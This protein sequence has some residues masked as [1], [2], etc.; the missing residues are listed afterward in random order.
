MR[1]ILHACGTLLLALLFVVPASLT[2]HAQAGNQLRFDGIN[3]RVTM[4]AFDFANQSFTIEFWARRQGGF[5]AYQYVFSQGSSTAGE[6]AGVLFRLNN[7]LSFSFWSDDL[8]ATT[9]VTDINWHH[10][11]CTYNNTTRLQAIYIDGVLNASRTA[12][13][14]TT[15]VGTAYLGSVGGT[16]QYFVGMMD[17]FRVWNYDLGAAVI[18]QRKNC[19]LSGSEPG[20][21]RY[22]RFNQG[23]GAGVNT[24]LTTLTDASPTAAN[25]TLVNFALSG[26]SSNWLSAS[27]A[28]ISGTTAPAAPTVAA[29]GKCTGSTLASLSPAPASTTLWFASQTSTAVLPSN[30]VLSSG[31]YF[32]A[33]A[34]T[35]GCRSSRSEAA[36]TIVTV[37]APSTSAQAFCAAATVNDLV[38]DGASIKWYNTP[39]GGSALPLSTNLSTR[40]Y[41]ASQTENGCESG[42]AASSVTVKPLPAAPTPAAGS[43][44]YCQNSPT[45][46]LA[47]TGNNLLWYTQ[48]SG[49]TASATAP[50]PSSAD[51]G[52]STW[53]VSQTVAGCEGPMAPIAV[54]VKAVFPITYS[55]VPSSFCIGS[56]LPALAPSGPGPSSAPARMVTTLAGAPASGLVDAIG[57]AAR[58]NGPTAI[59]CDTAGNL[60]V[61]DSKNGRIRRLARNGVVTTLASGLSTPTG[62]AIDAGGN[63]YVAEQAAHRIRTVTPQGVVTILAGGT[64]GFSNGVGTSASFNNPTALAVDESGNVYV[65]DRNNHCIRKITPGGVVT[66]FAGARTGFPANEPSI[67]TQFTSPVAIARTPS[68]IIYVA[69]MGGSRIRKITQDSTVS[70][71]AGGSAGFSDGAAATASFFHPSGIAVDEAG[72]VYIGDRGNNRIRKISSNGVVSTIAGT[73]STPSADGA[74]LSANVQTPMGLVFDR[75]GNLCFVEEDGNQV[76]KVSA[77]ALSLSRPLPAGLTFN[78]STGAI[79]GLPTVATPSASY[80]VANANGCGGTATLTFEIAPASMS[81]AALNTAQTLNV[82][83]STTYNTNCALLITSVAPTGSHPVSGNTAARVWIEP[84]QPEGYVRRHYEI[85]PATDPES[86]SGTVTLYFSQADFDAFNATNVRKLPAGP[87]DSAGIANLRIEKRSGTSN[88]GSG[89]PGTYNGGIINIDPSDAHIIWNATG[90]RWEVTFDV[91]GFSG[92]FA[93]TQSAPLPLTLLSFEGRVAGNGVGVS[94][95]TTDERALSHFVVERSNGDRRFEAIGTVAAQNSAGMHRYQLL[96]AAPWVSPV[97]L[98]RLRSADLDGSFRYSAMVHVRRSAGGGVQVYPTLVRHSVT[99]LAAGALVNTEASLCDLSGRELRRIPLR[100][101]TTVSDLSALAAGCYLLRFADGSVERIVRP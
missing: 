94:W 47:A 86:A 44:S 37:A 50:T 77:A 58:F 49:G 79:T 42:R 60:Y 17:E 80:I 53:W 36:V 78:E 10:Y 1:P 45:E 85:T 57:I 7:V 41:Y 34:T 95:T 89:L 6:F 70:V 69:E 90:A 52:I 75:E 100:S 12:T 83:G 88:D 31:S 15:A 74:A 46:A 38:A 92:F 21:V 99:I 43:I 93:K 35:S 25:G 48:A 66:T 72:N 55:D 84:A 18:A 3:D 22:Y 33:A 26:S 61:A 30:T 9:A 62:L 76:R 65:A 96:D 63:L 64:Q 20:L 19:E 56:A 68:G 101:G 73:G 97:R 54:E 4:P 13:A 81:L 27:P 51:P 29:Q 71:L 98:Y 24:G 8:D 5:G 28:V 11:A 23:T 32:V 67:V 82:S 40:S 39:T 16:G 14:N 59:V 91:E 2:A 87:Q